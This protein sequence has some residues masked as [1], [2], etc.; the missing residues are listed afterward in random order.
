MILIGDVHGKY[1][2]Y[3]NII[4]NHEESIQLGDFGF[5]LKFKFPD[6]GVSYIRLSP[7]CTLVDK[8]QEQSFVMRLCDFT[9]YNL[10][11]ISKVIPNEINTED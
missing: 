5:G 7:C 3:L 1:G 6:S 11:D 9:L 10:P 8:Y 4:K 2:Q